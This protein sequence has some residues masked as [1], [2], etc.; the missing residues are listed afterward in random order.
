MDQPPEAHPTAPAPKP[1]GASAQAAIPVPQ[2]PVTLLSKVAG[3][4]TLLSALPWIPVGSVWL[5][6]VELA[7]VGLGIMVIAI[8][9]LLAG[10]GI[11]R[12]SERARVTGI[13]YS[14]A[15]GAA[16]LVGFREI[17]ML[18]SDDNVFVDA[19]TSV[20]G[21][22]LYAYS[23]IVLCLRWRRPATT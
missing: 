8:V 3:L 15:L 20:P 5:G 13:V 22:V 6:L 7:P 10:I 19:L 17:L 18:I 21:F 14:L 11:L 4:I 9:Q 23:F 2:G 16:P 1:P 12:G